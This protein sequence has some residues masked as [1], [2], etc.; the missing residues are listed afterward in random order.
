MSLFNFINEIS[1]PLLD[2]VFNL[3]TSLYF[4]IP[5]IVVLALLIEKDKLKNI[6]IETNIR[7]VIPVILPVFLAFILTGIATTVIKEVVHE[8]RPC[9]VMHDINFPFCKDSN[10]FPSRHTAIA[11]AALPFLVYLRK[12]FVILLVYATLVGI[13]MIYLGQHYPHDVLAGFV[14]GFGIG[15]LFLLKSRWIAEKCGKILKI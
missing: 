15:Y 10:S 14:I 11:F 2:M 1:N 6:N 8:D 3:I 4:L 13:G 12:Y 7:S 9:K 5:V